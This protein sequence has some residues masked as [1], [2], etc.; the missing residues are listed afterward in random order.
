MLLEGQIFHIGKRS[1]TYG[2]GRRENL[3]YLLKTGNINMESSLLK[4]KHIHTHFPAEFAGKA[5]K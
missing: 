2:M 5:E 3:R 1:A 4:I